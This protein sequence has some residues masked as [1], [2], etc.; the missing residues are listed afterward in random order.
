[1][2]T[3]LKDGI[4]NAMSNIGNWIKGSVVD[5]IVNSV[6][7]FFGIHSPSKVMAG[8]G[9]HL[10]SGL[11]NGMMNSGAGSIAKTIFG[12]F[13]GALSALLQKGMIGIGG[14][15]TKALDAL[16]GAGGFIAS[17]ISK[18]LASIVVPYDG[19]KL[20]LYTLKMLQRA[21]KYLG[22]RIDISQGSFSTSVGA[23]AGTHAGGGAF[24]VS[25]PLSLAVVGA[26]RKAGFA[27][28]LRLPSQGPWAEHI[29]ALAMGDPRLSAPAMAQV[30]SFLRGG[31]GLASGYA[32]GG[33]INEP[34]WGVGKSGRRYTFGEKESELVV[35]GH[36]V[37]AG[38]NTQYI[39]INTQEI[40]PTRHAAQ[41]GWLL[42]NRVT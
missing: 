1:M 30:A 27:A 40:D 16:L 13:P 19:Q 32:N 24:D 38:G 37:G 23:S 28:W 41:L 33:W 15:P 29:H 14:L 22:H 2:I 5:P 35:P 20:D 39:T 9:G 25:S 4:N 26:L 31:S 8:L 10:I 34:I 12:G 11:L 36:K 18:A 21:E 17:G 42:A 7:K 6:K 3:G